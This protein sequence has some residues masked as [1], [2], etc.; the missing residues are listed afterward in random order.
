MKEIHVR[1][2]LKKSQHI[3]DHM[4]TTE[5][6]ANLFRATQAED[7]LLRENV[8]GKTKANQIHYEVGK[9][10]RQ[11][12][13]VNSMSDLFH[14]AVSDEFIFKV[15]EVMAK[16]SWHRFQVLTKRSERLAELMFGDTD[17][18]QKTPPRERR[19]LF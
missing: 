1:K 2:K 15:F 18:K 5:L 16:A 6:A 8:K 9:K 4:G 13:F 10:V 12:I 11:T 17:S 7:K 3:L 19:G 14:K